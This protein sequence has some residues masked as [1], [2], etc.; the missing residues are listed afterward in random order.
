M[1]SFRRHVGFPLLATCASIA[2]CS[3][4]PD[5]VPL[6]DRLEKDTGTKWTVYTDPRSHEIRFLKA[7]A[8]IVAGGTVMKFVAGT[9]GPRPIAV[10]HGIE[11]DKATELTY[12]AAT[13]LSSTANF[14]V[15]AL[16]QIAEAVRMGDPEAV[17]IVR[18]AW[19]AVGVPKVPNVV[20]T[21]FASTFCT[22]PPPPTPLPPPPPPNNPCSGHGDSLI[23]DPAAPAQAIRCKNGAGLQNPNEGTEFCADPSTRCKQVSASDPTAVV[24][25]GV[26]VCE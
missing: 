16:A 3:S 2:A 26:L 18:C 13:G 7:F 10:P 4:D 25:D 6:A 23:C 12:W 15:A 22:A 14:E 24:K 19:Y 21:W 11:W 5:P 20:D 9:P 17:K 8:L 1:R